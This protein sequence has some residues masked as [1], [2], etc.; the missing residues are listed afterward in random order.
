MLVGEIRDRETAEIATHAALTGHLV[1]STLHTNDAP[2][3]IT[4]LIDLGV[5]PYLVA[6]TVE[7]VLAQRLV[8]LLCSHCKQAV[9][10]SPEQRH[11]LGEPTA[12]VYAAVGCDRCRGTGFRGRT[13]I[14][15]LVWMDE[16]VRALVVDQ[17]SSGE[18]RR[19]AASKG[20][21]SLREDGLRQVRAGTT[22]LDEI[23][24]V[25]EMGS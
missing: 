15:E 20:M 7:A 25:T 6:S 14:Y 23:L 16:E 13:G 2:S 5:A 1:L 8:R 10:P 9:E 3:A 18:L 17:R 4:R 21:I 11:L 22:T 12:A 19:A 24:R